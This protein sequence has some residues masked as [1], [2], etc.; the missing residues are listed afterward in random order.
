LPDSSVVLQL[1]EEAAV[2]LQIQQSVAESISTIAIASPQSAGHSP[3]SLSTSPNLPNVSNSQ[4]T[5]DGLT[6]NNLAQPHGNVT[7]MEQPVSPTGIPS[8]VN[9]VTNPCQEC[10]ITAEEKRPVSENTRFGVNAKTISLDT[11]PPSKATMSQGVYPVKSPPLEVVTEEL[12]A[13]VSCFDTLS[14]A[15]TNK[16]NLVLGHF[17]LGSTSEKLAGVSNLLVV[18]ATSEILIS[19]AQA[20]DGSHNNSLLVCSTTQSAT[21]FKNPSL[22]N[23]IQNT[24]PHVLSSDVGNIT[25]VVVMTEQRVQGD[26]EGSIFFL[27]ILMNMKRQTLSS[28]LLSHLNYKMKQEQKIVIYQILPRKLA[29]MIY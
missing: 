14:V 26:G 25:S 5:T 12:V 15:G 21:D 19:V 13:S 7:S 28:H 29:A 1:C 8:E 17:P 4:D 16:S 11:V 6:V 20:V 3:A 27:V 23:S 18:S 22:S 2:I 9:G 24:K 10:F